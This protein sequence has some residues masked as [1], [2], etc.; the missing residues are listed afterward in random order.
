MYRAK[1][2]RVRPLE[3]SL[4]D[5]EAGGE[6]YGSRIEK[7]FVA[8]GDALILDMNH[9][10]AILKKAKSCFPSLRQVSCYATA[11]NVAEKS[12]SELRELR[13]MGL[14]VLYIGP[15]SGDEQTLRRIAKGARPK[16]APR[17][18]PYLFDAH[19]AAGQRAKAAGMKVSAIFLLGVGGIA[20]SAVHAEAS[21]R[22]ATQMDP[23]FLAALTLTIVPGTPLAKT[24]QRTGFEVPDQ[25]GLLGELRQFVDLARPSDAL[26]RTNHA[27]NYLALGGRL[28]QDRERILEILDR[29]LSGSIPLREEWMRGL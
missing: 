29:A 19:V 4:Q 22:L 20:N 2:F 12:D 1:N 13:E 3:Q 16:G 6:I 7:V 27:S 15:E 23:S 11:E 17:D 26:F 21:A 5:L 10:E 14:K 24:A 9:W 18:K 8:D 25:M 28:P